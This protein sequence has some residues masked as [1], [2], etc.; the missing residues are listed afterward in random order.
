MDNTDTDIPEEYKK[1]I[2]DK[3]E[4]AASK[5]NWLL[6]GGKIIIE[7]ERPKPGKVRLVKALTIIE[8]INEI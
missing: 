3:F 5:G 8:T 2:R 4:L 6:Q 1:R 7:M